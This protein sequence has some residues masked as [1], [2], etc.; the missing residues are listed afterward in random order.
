MDQIYVDA[1]NV[2]SSLQ[3]Y[4]TAYTQ[5]LKCVEIQPKSDPNT[6]T[7]MRSTTT[8]QYVYDTANCPKPDPRQLLQQIEDLQSS[9][10]SII[11]TNKVNGSLQM[12]NA[13][14]DDVVKLRNELDGKLQELYQTNNSIPQIYQQDADSTA[15]M[16]ILWTIL[17][18]SLLYYIITKKNL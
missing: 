15:Y 9:I 8:N 13:S 4:N 16:V 10:T 12:T 6:G 2:Y 11:Q 7:F 18:S 3:N 17:A 5:Y 14:Y 1:S